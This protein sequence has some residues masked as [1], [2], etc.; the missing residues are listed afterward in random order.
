MKKGGL[1]AAQFKRHAGGTSERVGYPTPPARVCNVA[2]KCATRLPIRQS[3]FSRRFYA[4][5]SSRS[6]AAITAGSVGSTAEVKL[7]FN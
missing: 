5:G 1:A 3:G 2:H 4:A 6:M 7:A